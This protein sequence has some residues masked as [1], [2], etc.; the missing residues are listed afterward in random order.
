MGKGL[1]AMIRT[2]CPACRREI[3]FAAGECALM[4]GCDGAPAAYAFVCP[5][6]TEPVLRRADSKAVAMLLV[7]GASPGGAKE[8][9]L[10]LLPPEG[11]GP[12]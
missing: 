3:D 11:S 5:H 9:A 12:A 6:C 8:P 7:G 10:R 2:R 1:V 4:P